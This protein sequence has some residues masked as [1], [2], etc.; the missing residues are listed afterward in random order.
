[1]SATVSAAADRDTERSIPM[2]WLVV[3]AALSVLALLFAF[4]QVVHGAVQKAQSQRI[5]ESAQAD[6][7]WRCKYLPSRAERNAC[8]AA[9]SVGS[10]SGS[11]VVAGGSRSLTASAMPRP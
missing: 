8:L 11:A 4:Q 7:A 2:F 1:M 6:S 9:L 3:F 5:A 10:G